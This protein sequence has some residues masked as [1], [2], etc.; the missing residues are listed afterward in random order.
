MTDRYLTSITPDSF[1]G[2]IFGFEGMQ[3]TV[4][5]LNGP[6]GCKFYHSSV[7][8]DQ[9]LR[10]KEFDPLNYPLLYYFG[11][12]RVPCTYLDKRDYI[13]GSRMKL[14]ELLNFIKK[15]SPADLLIV[16]NSPGAALIGDNLSQIVEGVVGYLR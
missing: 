14:E 13:Y 1:S 16:V 12:P 11:Q 9:G 5:A 3:N 7:S 4:V 8:D 6:T 2:L 15:E 10:Q